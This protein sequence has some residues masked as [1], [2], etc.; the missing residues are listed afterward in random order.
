MQFWRKLRYSFVE[1]VR[2]TYEIAKHEGLLRFII[3]I[4][5]ILF[6]AAVF[7]FIFEFNS[8]GNQFDSF[9]D[10]LWWSII[11]VATVGYGDIT[12]VTTGG[13]LVATGAILIFML[14]LMPLYA[15]S[16]T[17][18]YVS[19]RIKEGKGCLNVLHPE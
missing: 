8:N 7:A 9:W 5:T 19:K 18:V 1:S 14:L 15:A 11:T 10:A 17:A 6:L 2:E 13:K 4:F 16:I 3:I 12:P